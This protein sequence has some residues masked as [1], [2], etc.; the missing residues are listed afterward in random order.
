MAETIQIVTISEILNKTGISRDKFYRVIYNHVP[1]VPSTGKEAKYNL[2]QVLERLNYWE[3]KEK[4]KAGRKPKI[5][6]T[7]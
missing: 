4:K 1:E 3:T 6:M 2:E 5:V 7:N